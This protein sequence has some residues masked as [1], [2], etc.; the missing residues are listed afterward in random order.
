[1]LWLSSNLLLFALA[2]EAIQ[3]EPSAVGI[4]V[5]EVKEKYSHYIHYNGTAGARPD[6]LANDTEASILP[7]QSTSYWYENIAHQ[8]ISAFG[9]S[10]YAVYRN[11][12]D[13]GATGKFHASNYTPELMRGI[14]QWR[15]GRHCRYQCGHQCWWSLR[16]GLRVQHHHTRSRVFPRRHLPHLIFYRRLLLHPAHWKPQ[17]TSH[18]SCH[19]FIL[20]LWAHRW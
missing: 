17:F 14:R 5:A 15:D 2:I 10:G 20:G 19:L 7:R 18:N 11:V 16:R 3:F 1:M 12:K 8:G 9:P 6:I 4:V 13:Y